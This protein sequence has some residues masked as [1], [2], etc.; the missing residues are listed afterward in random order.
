MRVYFT[1][2][3][4]QRMSLRV[5]S[6]DEV[7]MVLLNGRFEREEENKYIVTYMHYRLIVRY[8]KDMIV[9][10]TAMYNNKFTNKVK[11]YAKKHGISRRKAI[12]ILKKTA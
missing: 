11:K 1:Q 5:I 3:A 9:V 12:K 4:K 2:H 6:E 8:N 7:K 10:I